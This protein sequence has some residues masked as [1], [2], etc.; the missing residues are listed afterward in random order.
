MLNFKSLDF[1]E[2]TYS[3]SILDK[4]INMEMI[5]ANLDARNC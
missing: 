4:L 5:L 3:L 2:S 1:P